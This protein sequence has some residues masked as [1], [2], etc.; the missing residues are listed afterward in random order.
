MIKASV[1]AIALIA[2]PFAAEAADMPTKA[3]YFKGTPRSVVSYYNWTGFYGGFN[4]GYGFGRSTWD[5]PAVSPEPKGMLYGL[6][7]G[8]N[9]Q[10]GSFV[11]GLEG[12]YAWSQMKG[13]VDCG[14]G[15]TCETKNTQFATIRGRLGY[16][17]DRWLPYV[18][19]GGAYGD[20]KATIS[21]PAGVVVTS[22]KSQF[23]WTV[24]AGVEYAFL[25]NWSAKLEYLY[26]DLGKF[27]T[28]FTA[29]VIDNV[30]FTTSIVRAGLNYKFSGPVMSRF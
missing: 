11:Y 18:T 28:G 10:V 16:A 3:P 23:G 6:T 17:F 21:S 25:G 26:A 12:D 2:T 22:S 8:Y 20:I 30:S 15:V 24:G 1:A 9:W 4:V 19:A 29:P 5:F 27:D 14:V 7:A 13:S